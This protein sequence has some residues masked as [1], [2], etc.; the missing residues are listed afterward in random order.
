MLTK[1]LKG[2]I[3]RATVTDVHL[4][5]PGSIGI[6]SKLLEAARIIPYEAV[7]VLDVTNGSRLET[8]AIPEDP[9]SGK[10][11]VLG[12][13]AHL[14]KKNDIIIIMSFGYFTSEDVR[15]FKPK[16]IVANE[17]NGIKEIL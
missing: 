8:Y 14:V 15:D 7:Q 11:I 5:Y 10:V 1:I 3:H 17:K 9:G 6:D 16:I 12:A 4:E 13:A 2:K